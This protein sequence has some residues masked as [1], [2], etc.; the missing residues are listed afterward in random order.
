MSKVDDNGDVVKTGGRKKGQLN[1]RTQDV[2]DRLAELDCDPIGGMA[3]I[4][5]KAFED[6]DY[7]LSGQMCKELANYVAPKRKAVEHTGK[8]GQDILIDT[9]FRVELID[10]K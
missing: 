2:I 5:K 8:D 9:V 3:I 7:I 1:R 6:G 10:P 4:A